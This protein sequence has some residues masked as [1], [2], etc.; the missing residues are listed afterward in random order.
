MQPNN[1][2]ARSSTGRAEVSYPLVDE[3]RQIVSAM[4]EQ[5]APFKGSG[6]APVEPDHLGVGGRSPV[7]PG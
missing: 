5:V 3:D 2:T 4:R 6:V 7:L 1:K